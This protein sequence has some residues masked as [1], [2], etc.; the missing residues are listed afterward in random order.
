M[1]RFPK[2]IHVTEYQDNDGSK[3]LQV[4]GGGVLGIDEPKPVALYQLVEVGT[5][6]INK[7]FVSKKRTRR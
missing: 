1:A 5:V 6:E 4:E 2:L 7:R 3:W